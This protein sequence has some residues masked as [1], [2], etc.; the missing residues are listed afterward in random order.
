M[1]AYQY[2]LTSGIKEG[3]G[4]SPAF[5]VKYYLNYNQDLKNA[6]GDN[7]AAAYEHFITIGKYEKRDL[8]PVINL[9]FGTTASAI[10]KN[11]SCESEYLPDFN[12]IFSIFL[13]ELLSN[14]IQNRMLSCLFTILS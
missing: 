9:L 3:H 7:Y 1:Q 10:A 2:F 5:D 14:D 4:A 8:S 6:F 11:K 12:L 13:E